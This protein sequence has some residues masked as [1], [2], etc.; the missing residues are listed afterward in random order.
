MLKEKSSHNNK[1]ELVALDQLVPEDHLLRKID[2]TISFR[3]IYEKVEHLYCKD[4]GRP[5]VDP[6]L[7]F[8]MMFLGY[9]YGIRSERR[10]E[11]EVQVN[12]AYRWFLGLGLNDR[13]PDHSTI[14]RN[15]TERFAGTGVFQ[16]IFDE[17]VLQAIRK[18][19]ID[20][21]TLY[22]DS[23]HIKASANKHRFSKKKVKKSNRAYLDD[24]DAAI[25]AERVLHGKQPLKPSSKDATVEKEIKVSTTDP[26]SGYMVRDNKPK[27]FF[28]L[29]HRTV[30][31]KHNLITDAHVTPGNV[32]DSI[33]YLDRL[34]HQ[35]ERFGFEVDSVGL[36]A[37][38]YNAPICRGLSSRD[39]YGVM[40]YVRPYGKKGIMKKSEFQYDGENNCY[41]CPQ[42]QKLRYATTNRNGYHEYKSKGKLCGQ[43]PLLASCTESKNHVKVITR[44]IWEASKEDVNSH[45]FDEEGKRIYAR[46]KETVE[47]SFADAK[48][49]HGYR[50]AR[51][52]GLAK[53]QEQSLMVAIA[54]NI[55]KMALIMDRKGHLSHI[56]AYL[57]LFF[58]PY[59]LQKQFHSV[60]KRYALK[61][62]F[63]C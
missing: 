4:N 7:L 2:K 46:R 36:D 44:H 38:Y 27:G 1:M 31:G 51:Y 52:R 6:V 21:R 55:K 45:R 35:V 24:L 8:K 20:G 11:Q 15:R 18:R 60:S 63:S 39:I 42:G 17:I 10:L 34:D 54:Q 37:G 30:D 13:V 58:A 25:E 56:C 23:T 3:F 12:V 48:E 22:T 32:H 40:P 57:K 61:L 28:Y 43:C 49:L 41:V 47:R 29:D 19:L 53:M 33:P 9:L 50:Y 26:E 14:S 59:R 16:V 5:P 62:A